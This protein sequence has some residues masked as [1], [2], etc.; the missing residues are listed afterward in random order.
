MFLRYLNDL[1]NCVV[2]YNGYK[3]VFCYYN[4]EN[5][6]L[7][8]YLIVSLSMVWFVKVVG[9][10]NNNLFVLFWK[11]GFFYLMLK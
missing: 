5:Y 6:S 2:I 7:C 3:K 8:V 11:E 9:I 1:K 4:S 10:C